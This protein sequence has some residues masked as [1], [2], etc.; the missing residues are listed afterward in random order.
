MITTNK[1]GLTHSKVWKKISFLWAIPRWIYLYVWDH[2]PVGRSTSSASTFWQMVSHSSLVWKRIH[3]GYYDCKLARPWGSKAATNHNSS[4][5]MRYSWYEV[6]LM[7]CCHRFLPNMASGTVAK[8][9]P[10]LVRPSRTVPEWSLPRYRLA[11][12]SL[13]V[14]D[15][16][17]QIKDP[18]QQSMGSSIPVSPLLCLLGDSQT[19]TLFP[20]S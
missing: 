3:S 19:E 5:T 18:I 1:T 6:L 4:T 15:V 13:V 16:G 17:F 2:Y 14:G 20:Y 11:H 8:L 12:I 7:K 10:R 9:T